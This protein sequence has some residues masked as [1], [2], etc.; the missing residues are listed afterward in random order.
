MTDQPILCICDRC[1][2][3]GIAGEGAFTGLGDLLD[4]EPVPRKPR[5]DGWTP[6]R[7]R[8]FIA[9][10]A[11]SGSRKAAAEAVGMSESGVTH[12]LNSE[13]SEGFR[14]A[15]EAAQRVALEEGRFRVA[16]SELRGGEPAGQMRREGSGGGCSA[17]PEQTPEQAKAKEVEAVEDFLKVILR[18]YVLKA[19]QERDR[20]LEGKIVE[21][22]WYLRQ[23]TWLEV[24]IDVGAQGDG[25]AVLERLRRGDIPIG[26]V[27]ETPMSRLLGEARRTVWAARGEPE[28][29]EH[30][31]RRYLVQHDGF[32]TEPGES[33]PRDGLSVDETW[34]RFDEQHAA[35]ARAQIEW[36]ARAAEQSAAWRARVDGSRES[37]E[38]GGGEA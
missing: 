36:E 35:D 18:K 11:L 9:G 4:F 22:D 23:L 38:G 24:A 17:E 31:P 26:D 16:Q 20:R 34:R 2:A 3:E 29:P 32:C 8:A 33:A 28:R 5:T 37:D 13:G 10:V 30:P 15:L 25:F 7:Q 6:G 21:A 12:L 14:R 1:R 27:V 19:G